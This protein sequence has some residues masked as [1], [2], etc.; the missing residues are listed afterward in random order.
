[1]GMEP[2]R[3]ASSLLWRGLENP[4]RTQ[5]VNGLQFRLTPNT[6]IRAFF[7][8][9]T[10]LFL[11][12]ENGHAFVRIILVHDVYLFNLG[13]PAPVHRSS[14]WCGLDRSRR[15]DG[16]FSNH[17]RHLLH[18]TSFGLESRGRKSAGSVPYL[19]QI[20]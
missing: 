11:V 1:M 12:S 18:V 13:G 9:P 17:S 20:P 8:L 2:K 5:W 4:A 14:A 19:P 10:R 7:R 6:A 16:C 15:S 3:W